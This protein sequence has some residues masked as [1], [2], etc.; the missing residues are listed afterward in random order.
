MVIT[1]VVTCLAQVRSARNTFHSHGSGAA[2][3]LAVFYY[4]DARTVRCTYA[5]AGVAYHHCPTARL[6]AACSTGSRWHRFSVISGVG[7]I[8]RDCAVRRSSNLK[9]LKYTTFDG[10]PSKYD[11][12]AFSFKRAIRS[13]NCDAYTMLVHVER[14]TDEFQEDVVD[15]QFESLRM[16]SVAAEL[17]DLLCQACT[18]DALSCTRHVLWKICADSL[19]G[20]D[21]TRS[22]TP[23]PWRE[24]FA[25]SRQSLAEGR[26]VEARGRRRW[27]SGRSK[28][29][30]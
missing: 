1:D 27:T 19:L 15:P 25:L 24:P 18:E 22:T 16:E 14:A 29:R 6:V 30:S 12:W 13:S 26:R 11:D 4:V 5:A 3:I 7:G 8:A 2:L 17:Y 23:G 9:H 21:Y 10:I 20:N 28:A